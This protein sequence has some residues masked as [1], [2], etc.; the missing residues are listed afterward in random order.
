MDTGNNSVAFSPLPVHF[1]ELYLM[2]SKINLRQHF[3]S[4]IWFSLSLLRRGGSFYWMGFDFSVLNISIFYWAVFQI[5]GVSVF[6]VAV[7]DKEVPRL[8]GGQ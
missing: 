7:P 4:S 8:D 5:F 1:L 3:L 6:G 2:L